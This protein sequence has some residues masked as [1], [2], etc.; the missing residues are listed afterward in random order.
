MRPRRDVL[1]YLPFR[2]WINRKE[3]AVSKI[4]AE[5]TRKNVQYGVVGEENF[6]EQLKKARV[7]LVEDSGALN[8]SERNQIQEFE[9]SGGRTIFADSQ[10]WLDRAM[11]AIDKPSLVLQAP[12]TV[13]GVVR[14]T[15]NGAVV[16]FYNLNIERVSSFEDRVTPAE[17]LTVSV[18][19]PFKSIKSAKL[20]SVDEGIASGQVEHSEKED[21]EGCIVTVQVPRLDVAQLLIIEKRND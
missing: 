3:C 5:L 7:V 1:L 19:V 9:L 15:V 18:R 16:F 10:K 2:Q 21:S 8:A 12:K 11:K 17:N 14:D 4:A 6:A 13:R 20:S